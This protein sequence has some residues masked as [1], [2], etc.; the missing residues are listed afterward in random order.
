MHVEAAR[1]IIEYLNATAHLDLTFRRDSKLEDVQLEYDL[2][3]YVDVDCAH[4][5]DDRPSV[6]AVAVCCEGTLVSWFSRTQTCVT[7]ST[8]ETEYGPMANG[9]KGALYVRGVL[10]FLM[11]SWGSPSIGVF[12]DN[13]GAID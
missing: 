7:I 4:K 13:E 3:T 5:A 11:N 6:S 9:A 8:T 2:E 12:E 10:V 1:K